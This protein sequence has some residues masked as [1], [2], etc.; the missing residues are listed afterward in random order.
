[1]VPTVTFALYLQKEGRERGADGTFH[2]H[3]FFPSYYCGFYYQWTTWN[4]TSTGRY[5]DLSQQKSQASRK[6]TILLKVE[7]L[8]KVRNQNIEKGNPLK[9]IFKSSKWE[10]PTERRKVLSP[11]ELK[12]EG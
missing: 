11:D 12:F 1:M 6:E 5:S 3:F 7:T 10:S 2:S 8:S 9:K 4:S